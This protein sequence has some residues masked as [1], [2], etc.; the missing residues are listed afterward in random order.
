MS[1]PGTTVYLVG[2]GPGDP[3]LITVRGASLVRDCD[4]LLYDS[5][6]SADLVSASRARDKIYVGKP[7]GGHERTQDEINALL[8][9]YA[10]TGPARRIVRLKGGDPFVFGRGGEEVA[11]CVAAG[12]ACQVVPG[13]TAGL[14]VPAV[15]GVPATLRGTSSGVVLVTAAASAEGDGGPSWASLVASRLTL[16]FYMGAAR[17]D[18]IA[19]GLLSHG[20]DPATPAL[21]IQDG[22]LPAMRVVACPLA[23]LSR[24]AAQAGIRPPAI[25]LV[26][27]VARRLDLA[28]AY[29]TRPLVGRTV[30]IACA[31]GSEYPEADGL[32]AL[33]ARVVELPVV[34][35]LPL[36]G[37]PS[38][39]AMV[40]ALAP[41]DAVV[42][43]SARAAEYLVD[44]CRLYRPD[45][46]LASLAICARSSRVAAQVQSRH[47]ASGFANLVIPPRAGSEHVPAALAERGISPPR[48]VW[49]LRSRQAQ[50]PLPEALA[51]AGYD[52]CDVALYD[53]VPVGVPPDLAKLVIG[54]TV[55][56]L[57]LAAPSCARAIAAAIP[58]LCAPT[59]PVPVVG[60]IG[61]RLAAVARALGFVPSVVPE[62]PE[63][64]GLL[65]GI[66][67][68]LARLRP[69][70]A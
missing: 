25:V 31:E 43:T 22:T 20:M 35:T 13:V 21:A 27:S 29:R 63:M 66:G 3:G 42:L 4:V 23:D 34:R 69:R 33:G 17:V 16:V 51:E 41:S 12:I 36:F 5:L 56:A 37:A 47:A 50:G 19:H 64:A 54:G 52:V 44:A 8:V 26:G 48:R 70:S 32:R 45:A 14:A 39:R 28:R 10:T 62:D 59:S 40:L 18:A 24:A 6:V 7:R 58:E 38:V 11:A 55:D 53:S 68:A 15:L 49:L 60:V 57:V 65:D 9:A 30:V 1:A 67:A 46:P 2:A 61:S